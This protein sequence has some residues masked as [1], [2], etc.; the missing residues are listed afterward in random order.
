MILR[1][2]ILAAAIVALIAATS[3]A[4]TSLTATTVEAGSCADQCRAKHSQCRIK[5]KGRG[6]CDQ[7]LSQCINKCRR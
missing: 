6:N 7:A 2:T 5:T 1:T 4:V 3:F